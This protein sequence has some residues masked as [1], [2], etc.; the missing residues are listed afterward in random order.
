[1]ELY[2]SVYIMDA[3]NDT[4]STTVN[5]PLLEPTKRSVRFQIENINSKPIS[6]VQNYAHLTLEWNVGEAPQNH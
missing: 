3:L 2:G 5:H 6:D 4:N 1:M